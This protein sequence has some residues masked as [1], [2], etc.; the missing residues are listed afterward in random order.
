MAYHSLKTQETTIFETERSFENGLG[1]L[2]FIR[3]ILTLPRRWKKRVQD[4][5]HLSQ[6]DDHVLSDIGLTRAD[7]TCEATRPFWQ[8]LDPRSGRS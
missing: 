6:L 8:P 7:V 1:S 4:R 5:R 2:M 3:S